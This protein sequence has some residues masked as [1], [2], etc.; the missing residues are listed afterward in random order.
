[1]NE[2]LLLQAIEELHTKDKKASLAGDTETLLDI[3]TENGIAI[4]YEGDII[5]G[6]EGHSILET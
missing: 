2:N 3:F 1:M 5:K 6:R 4:P